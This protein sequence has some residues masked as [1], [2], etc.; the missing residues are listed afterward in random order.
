[1]ENSVRI[2]TNPDVRSGQPIVRGTRTTVA[3]I[4]A[5][6]GAGASETEILGDFPWL[7]S[8]DINSA[9]EYAAREL[10]RKVAK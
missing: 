9:L 4:L 1:M 5:L 3:D 7:T 6:L 10:G 2:T 8:E